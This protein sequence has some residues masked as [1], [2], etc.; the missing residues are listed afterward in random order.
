MTRS[1]YILDRAVLG[2]EQTLRAQAVIDRQA[3]YMTRTIEDL[4]DVTRISSGKIQLQPE[5]VSTWMRSRSARSKTIVEL[6][7][8]AEL[9]SRCW[10]PRNRCGWRATGRAFG[11]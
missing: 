2:G 6:S 5:R 3:G 4:L 10:R 8:R 11:K 1:I 9:G 7:S